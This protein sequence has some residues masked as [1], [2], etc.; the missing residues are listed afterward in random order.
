MLN[1]DKIPTL[2]LAVEQNRVLGVAQLKFREMDI[3]PDKEHWLGG[4]YV[5]K[6][7][8]GR[9]VAA[10]LISKA[11]ELAKSFQV[12]TLYLQTE[13]LDG[14]L[15]AHLGWQPI[16]KAFYNGHNVLVMENKL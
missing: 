10:K 6:A 7:S 14:G 3:Y 16:E 9:G 15:Y 1:R 4:V 2:I 12:Q 11:I 5:D 13:R 8:R